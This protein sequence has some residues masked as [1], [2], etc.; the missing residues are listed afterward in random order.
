M[1]CMKRKN[2]NPI[3]WITDKIE[4]WDAAGG[5]SISYKGEDI[6]CLIRDVNVYDDDV[7]SFKVGDFIST[8]GKL[9]QIECANLWEIIHIYE[10]DQYHNDKCKRMLISDCWKSIKL[11]SRTLYAH[12]SGFGSD[13]RF[14][15]R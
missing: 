3:I 10:P 9:I 5:D 12:K 14:I 13:W 15:F 4:E 7:N 11:E 8:D 2:E 1:K 6:S